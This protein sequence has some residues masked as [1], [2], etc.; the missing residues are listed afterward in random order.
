M[1][2]IARLPVVT[3]PALAGVPACH[4]PLHAVPASRLN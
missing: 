1:L 4:Q 2:K 3:R